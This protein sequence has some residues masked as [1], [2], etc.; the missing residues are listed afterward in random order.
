VSNE[1]RTGDA[2]PPCST[3]R[4]C[5]TVGPAI[6]LEWYDGPLIEIARVEFEQRDPLVEISTSLVCRVTGEAPRQT[7]V[8]RLSREHLVR[9]LDLVDGKPVEDHDGTIHQAADRSR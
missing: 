1:Q 3:Q 8:L 7:V 5:G 9:M 4:G 6:A 2:A